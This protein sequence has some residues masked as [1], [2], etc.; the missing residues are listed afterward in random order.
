MISGLLQWS[1]MWH[2]P[3][4]SR[5]HVGLERTRLLTS[6]DDL[7]FY[8]FSF[9]LVQ[10]RNSSLQQSRLHRA[11]ARGKSW[12]VPQ[13]TP[14]KT[15]HTSQVPC[16]SR[17]HVVTPSSPQTRRG[18]SDASPRTWLLASPRTGRSDATN[19]APGLILLG[20]RMLPGSLRPWPFGPFKKEA[21]SL[22]HWVSF[23]FLYRLDGRWGLRQC[24]V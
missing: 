12:Q 18:R 3:S 22:G 23:C 24:G 6:Y 19:G 15:S 1:M 13:I 7:H 17:L 21:R 16:D 2:I 11:P 4:W 10:H 5:I 14:A 9:G 8:H 20:T